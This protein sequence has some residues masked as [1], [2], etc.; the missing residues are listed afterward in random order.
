M[1]I[2]SVY[3]SI[4]Y[5]IY[6]IYLKKK[7]LKRNLVIKC[8]RTPRCSGG[9]QQVNS[10]RCHA[11]PARRALYRAL[12]GPRAAARKSSGIILCSGNNARP[13]AAAA[14]QHVIGRRSSLRVGGAY[15]NI[16]NIIFVR[17]LCLNN[18]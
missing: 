8:A 5:V 11:G 9:V 3:I 13:S 4:F 10:G 6:Y 16:R 17:I 7:K 12:A 15:Y 2:P 1:Y 14:V 18:V